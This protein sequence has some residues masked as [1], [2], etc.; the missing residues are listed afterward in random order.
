MILGEIVIS[1]CGKDRR[2]VGAAGPP[3]WSSVSPGVLSWVVAAG[4]DLRSRDEEGLGG[5]RML[6]PGVSP[7]PLGVD[8]QEQRVMTRPAPTQPTDRLTQRLGQAGPV[9]QIPQQPGPGMRRHAVPVRGYRDP[10]SARCRLH[11]RS[12]SR[13]GG[14]GSSTRPES[15]TEQALSRLR[16]PCRA[17]RSDHYRSSRVRYEPSH[18]WRDVT[19]QR[20]TYSAAIGGREIQSL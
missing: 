17:T 7:G 18:E 11:S 8:P 6:R 15:Q 20:F 9:G 16:A 5:G 2:S 14:S 13:L 1:R 10:G 12:A 3:T 4:R 19:L